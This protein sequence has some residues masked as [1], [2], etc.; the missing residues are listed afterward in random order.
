[1]LTGA[2]FGLVG[3]VIFGI[4]KAI[5]AEGAIGQMNR[6]FKAL[7]T[8]G[9]EAARSEVDK[10]F[11]PQSRPDR[12]FAPRYA[13]LSLIGD[14]VTLE[15]E[16]GA[17][18]GPIKNICLGKSYGLLGLV[19]VGDPTAPGKLAEHAATCERELPRMMAK[20]KEA[21][22]GIATIGAGVVS[23]ST[24]SISK[25]RPGLFI[26]GTPWTKALL[27][28]AVVRSFERDGKTEFAANARGNLAHLD[29]ARHAA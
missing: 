12:V 7:R 9:L 21:V 18:N 23:G 8:G 20:I 4:I 6:V 13:A 26:F 19:L 15:R 2:L 10:T 24:D 25:L 16:V 29:R 14:R 27:W 5:T 28:D 1:M 22:R 17:I 11:K 3:A